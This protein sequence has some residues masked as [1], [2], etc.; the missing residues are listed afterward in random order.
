MSALLAPL[1]AIGL[2]RWAP[3]AMRN[4]WAALLTPAKILT[5]A[6]ATMVFG[7]TFGGIWRLIYLWLG[8]PDSM[9]SSVNPWVGFPVY[10]ALISLVLYLLSTRRETDP[11]MPHLLWVVGLGAAGVMAVGFAIRLLG[12]GTLLG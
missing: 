9:T 10:L 7:V 12:L 11:P 5:I 8:H 4:L 2:W 6:V 3:G 1:G